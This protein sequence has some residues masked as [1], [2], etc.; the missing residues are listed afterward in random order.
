MSG[1]N[2]SV[3]PDKVSRDFIAVY[4]HSVRDVYSY[5]A[6]RVGDRSTAEDLTQEVF[7]AGAQRFA[8]G[9]DVDTPWLIG[10]ARHKLVDHW[11][12]RSREDRKLALVHAWGSRDDAPA[13]PVDVGAATAALAE[14]N[15]TYRV[16][17]VL[18]HVDDLPVAEVAA[19]LG[20]TLEA[21]EQVLTR[22][23]T[24][25]RHVYQEPAR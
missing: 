18:R 23:R 7:I 6:S 2:V 12:A 1:A 3:T 9:H 22:A 25:F 5:F 16:A 19:H 20:R 11:R 10:V 13:G 4:R 15:P 21:T 17:L 14:L 24:A 8:G